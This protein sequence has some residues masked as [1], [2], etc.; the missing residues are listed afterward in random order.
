MNKKGV[1]IGIIVVV[2]IAGIIAGIISSVSS[3]PS[4]T[5]NLDMGRIPV[6]FI[7]NSND[8]Q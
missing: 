4:E 3:S 2:I 5:M 7:V 1:M 8:Q 6:F